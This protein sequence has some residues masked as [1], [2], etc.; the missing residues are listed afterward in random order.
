MR[1]LLVC[2]VFLSTN[3]LAQFQLP[4]NQTGQVQYQEIVRIGDG[5][6]P[7]RPI[8]DRVRAWARQRYPAANSA[9]LHYDEQHGIAFVRSFYAI[10]N[11]NIRYTL[12]IEARIGRYRATITDLI[13]EQG[14]LNQPVRPVSSSADEM[15]RVTA[16]SVKDNRLIEQVAANQ[17]AL[18]Q[19]IDQLCRTTLAD[20][21]QTMTGQTDKKGE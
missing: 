16:S 11:R 21:K 7:A 10:G 20:L 8:F 3:A 9:E 17:T 2:L 13:D 4:T 5:K 18:Y 12:T 6:G 14:G 15:K 19:Q 1:N